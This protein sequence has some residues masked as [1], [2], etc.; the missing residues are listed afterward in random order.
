MP[1]HNSKRRSSREN[2]YPTATSSGGESDGPS[3]RA[4]RE[5]FLERNRI[6]AS[7]CRQKKKE[8]TQQLQSKYARLAE[9]KEDLLAEISHL[10]GEILHLKNE[11]LKHAQ[12]GDEPIRL[13]LAQ[14]VKKITASDSV[15]G[16]LQPPQAS[17][18]IDQQQS[19]IDT[20]PSVNGEI[21]FGFDD[22]MSLDLP[23]DFKSLE[24]IRSGSD[25]GFTT[26]DSFED[27]INV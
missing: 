16:A 21:N 1:R 20:P 18:R 22:P 19:E 11:V 7:K 10:R 25:L 13:H 15:L 12:C 23:S 3:A 8:H 2:P 5:R 17:K 27:L 24:Q 6:A 14:M 26:E 9:K 4:K